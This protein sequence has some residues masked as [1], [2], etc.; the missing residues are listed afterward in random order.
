MSY[1]YCHRCITVLQWPFGTAL[2]MHID[3][4]CSCGAAGFAGYNIYHYLFPPPVK[5]G[6]ATLQLRLVMADVERSLLDAYDSDR[7]IAAHGGS[8]MARMRPE[9]AAYFDAPNFGE[10]YAEM[11]GVG[12]SASIGLSRSLDSVNSAMGSHDDLAQ[13]RENTGAMEYATGALSESAGI[14]GSSR[15]VNASAGPAAGGSTAGVANVESSVPS[16]PVPRGGRAGT[17]T[18]QTPFQERK[19]ADLTLELEPPGTDESGSSNPLLPSLYSRYASPEHFAQQHFGS[20]VNSI[21]AVA[22]AAAA[23]AGGLAYSGSG[24]AAAGAAPEFR[25]LSISRSVDDG[26]LN[27]FFEN[28]VSADQLMGESGGRPKLSAVKRGM[29]YFHLYRLRTCFSHLFR[30][31]SFRQSPTWSIFSKEYWAV[32]SDKLSSFGPS[33][34]QW[35]TY[36]MLSLF[37]SLLLREDREYFSHDSEFRSILKDLSELFSPDFEI[38]GERKLA[39]ANRMRL[40]YQCLMPAP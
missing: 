8:Q 19:G 3:S 31:R 26:E 7:R 15:A 20:R 40:S 35:P 34:Q 9:P 25:R 4:C 27:A 22:G 6:K 10:T 21:N 39:A 1:Y 18:T 17:L 2:H 12:T 38:S 5:T 16:S 36:S 29:M 13:V 30:P 28:Q 11:G 33:G 23:A 14:N 32:Y 24:A 37:F